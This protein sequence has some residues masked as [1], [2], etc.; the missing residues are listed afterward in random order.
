MCISLSNNSRDRPRC[1]SCVEYTTIWQFGSITHMAILLSEQEKV[2]I[3]T[4]NGSIMRSLV[5]LELL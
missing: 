1:C 5:N 4:L 2:H 3:S